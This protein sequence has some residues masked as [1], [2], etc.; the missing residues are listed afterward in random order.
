M[1]IKLVFADWCRAGNVVDGEE[2][3][4]LALGSF[5]SGSTFTAEI[6]LDQDDASELFGRL[7]E[8]YQPQF[9]MR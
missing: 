4:E 3:C 7:A 9:Y 2:Y 1:L 5:H 8:G 6:H